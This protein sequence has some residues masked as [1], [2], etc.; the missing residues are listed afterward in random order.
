MFGVNN[1]QKLCIF[2]NCFFEVSI[3]QV[4]NPHCR[5]QFLNLIAVED[6]LVSCHRRSMFHHLVDNCW[7][8]PIVMAAL[9][10]RLIP[11]IVMAALFAQLIPKVLASFVLI[12]LVCPLD[13]GHRV[14]ESSGFV[15]SCYTS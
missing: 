14:P 8:P 6:N 3:N 5:S 2:F 11:P 7:L 15:V 9:F 4:L 1:G 12:P 10:A 13:Q